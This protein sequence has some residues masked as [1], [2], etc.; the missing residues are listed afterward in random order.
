MASNEPTKRRMALFRNNFLPYSETFIHDQ[1]RHHVR[2]D[3]EVFARQKR[4]TD[5]FV[6]HTVHAVESLPE[7]PNPVSSA[8][9]AATGR[10]GPF[11]QV[12]KSKTFDILHAHFGHNA[13][14]AMRYAKQ[15][16]A[17][18]VVSLHGRDVSILVGNDK[19]TPR[20]WHYTVGSKLLFKRVSR[21]LA[22][23]TELRDLIVQC[24]CP[25]EKV[26]VYRLGIDVGAFSPG[27]P[28][29]VG[30]AER[31]VMVG[32][33]VHKKGHMCGIRAVGHA[34]KAGHNVKAVLIGDGP[35][36]PEYDALIAEL[37]IENSVEF[38]GPL[39]HGDVVKTLQG[40]TALLAPSVVAKNQDRESGLIVAKEAAACGLPVVGTIHG[41]IPE[42]IDDGV[43]GF[44]VPEH[45]HIKMGQR[46]TELLDSRALREQMGQAA[47]QKMEREYD[48]SERVAVLEDLY[49]EVIAQY[50]ADKR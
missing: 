3:Y 42:I 5:R 25:P 21:F 20:W 40:A 24:G 34:I 6:G 31:V 11:E 47:R 48:I 27:Q 43:T 28:P 32:R 37:G 23:S 10:H 29:A 13:L 12:F 38:T 15:A 36:R 39:A 2:Y 4:N 45:D 9:Y 14:Y 41:G 7:S 26:T 19:Y 17:P 46:L 33:F 49:D 50:R 44:L 16:N 22:A 35:L 1:L 8:L 30:E 18:L